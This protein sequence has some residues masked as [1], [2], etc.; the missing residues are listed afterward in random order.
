MKIRLTV[1]CLLYFLFAITLVKGENFR[2]DSLRAELQNMKH[3]T[4]RV[5]ILNQLAESYLY[6]NQDSVLAIAKTSQKLAEEI[7]YD[8]GLAYALLY[9]GGVHFYAGKYQK[10]LE[11]FKSASDLF[12]QTNTKMGMA[13]AFTQMG[14]SYAELGNY[15]SAVKYYLDGLSIY[16][17]EASLAG[18]SLVHNN[19][20]IAYVQQKNTQKAIQHFESSIRIKKI[21][22]DTISITISLMNMAAFKHE[23]KQYDEALED[24]EAALKLL[25]KKPAPQLKITTFRNIGNIL[26]EIGKGE[27][28]LEYQNQALEYYQEFE[29]SERVAEVLIEI[30]GIYTLMSQKRKANTY[31][32][33]ALE[34]NKKLEGFPGLKA[35]YKQLAAINE[36]LGNWEDALL[37]NKQYLEM[38]K[39]IYDEETAARIARLEEDYIVK[40]KEADIVQLEKDNANKELE[41]SRLYNLLLIIGFM[42]LLI[43]L[44]TIFIVRY[45]TLQRKRQADNQERKRI[46]AEHRALRAQMNPHFIF[47]SLSSIQRLYI[48][49]NLPRANEYMAEFAHLM[50]NILDNSGKNLNS[51]KEELEMLRQY[52]NLEQARLDHKFNYEI[53]LDEGVDYLRS[54]IPSLVIQPF[55]ENAIWHGIVPKEGPG[56]IKII[57]NLIDENKL[58]CL[59]LDDGIGVTSSQQLRKSNFIQ[60]ESKSIKLTQAR[61]SLKNAVKLEDRPEG[62]T[63]VSII[64]PVSYENESS[65]H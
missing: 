9:I 33:E 49:G 60:H 10:S 51:I 17:S 47:N 29:D 32:L 12:K 45:R 64:I 61:L 41:I 37:Y 19:L 55:V 57:L 36:E 42:L 8:A 4:N 15:A 48:E 21:L 20:A 39:K 1:T 13:S 63:K 53:K 5:R 58:T 24:C 40:K 28:A 16:E 22:G 27:E 6:I 65:N 52:L 59:V 62:G 44:G 3:D 50:R 7:G 30:G 23:N 34:I 25:E 2:S 43:S 38:E 26:G 18:Q 56:E 35:N 54:Y 11:E 46:E 14:L 31:F